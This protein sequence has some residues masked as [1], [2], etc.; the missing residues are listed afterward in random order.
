MS[1]HQNPWKQVSM[2]SACP[3]T[4]GS[5]HSSAAC[6]VMRCEMGATLASEAW[7]ERGDGCWRARR[8]NPMASHG[9]DAVARRKLKSDCPLLVRG[10]VLGKVK[11]P[12][13]RRS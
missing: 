5:M 2:S 6:E 3:L 12:L 11:L 1:V 4:L 8:G 7:W 13:R 9:S 10:G